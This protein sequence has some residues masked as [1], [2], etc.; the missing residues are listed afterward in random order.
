VDGKDCT[1]KEAPNLVYLTN[2]VGPT[3][4]P[5]GGAT[6]GTTGGAT[7]G[8]TGANNIY[9]VP[10]DT[11]YVVINSLTPLRIILPKID[12]VFLVNGDK[13]PYDKRITISSVNSISHTVSIY[14]ESL[15]SLQSRINDKFTQVTLSGG[16][17]LTFI[18]ASKS[19]FT[20]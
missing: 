15:V 1:P 16:T 12:G 19:W 10:E 9:Y 3:G 2:I 7:G 5:T 13:Y 17:S 14:P 4:G 20:T 11:R 8:T 6:G 18:S